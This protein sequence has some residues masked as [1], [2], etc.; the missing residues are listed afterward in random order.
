MS[1]LDGCRRL[2]RR[3]ERKAEHLLA[4]YRAVSRVPTMT[5]STSPMGALTMP[6]V[7]A[8]RSGGSPTLSS[9]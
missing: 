6:S 3:Y 2:H 9:S 5:V 7:M 4:T 8:F 1:R